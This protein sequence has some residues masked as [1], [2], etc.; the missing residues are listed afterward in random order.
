MGLLETKPSILTPSPL[1]EA[2]RVEYDTNYKSK[3]NSE[4][5]NKL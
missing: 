3:N 4:G 2:Q 1:Q 5:E